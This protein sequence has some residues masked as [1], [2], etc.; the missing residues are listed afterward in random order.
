M[1]IDNEDV[2]GKQLTQEFYTLASNALGD[3]VAN[4]I[5]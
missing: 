2:D 3:Y 4:A 5:K 1:D